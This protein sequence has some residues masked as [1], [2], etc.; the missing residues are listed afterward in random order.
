MR[1]KGAIEARFNVWYEMPEFF[2]TLCITINYDF[3]DQFGTESATKVT[4]PRPLEARD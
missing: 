2:V 3:S 1:R 4:K